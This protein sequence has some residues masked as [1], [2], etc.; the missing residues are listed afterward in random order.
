[1]K[2]QT[3]TEYLIIVAIVII[4]ALVVV[5]TL[6]GVTGL[7]NRSAD[8]AILATQPLG[9]TSFTLTSGGA[10]FILKNNVAN[11]V[12]VESITLDGQL[13]SPA[14][15]TYPIT[16]AVG[17]AQQIR[18][19]AAF[20]RGLTGRAQIGITYIDLATN[21][22]YSKNGTIS[23]TFPALY[24][25]NNIIGYWSFDQMNDT[26]ITDVMGNTT[27][28]VRNV[29]TTRGVFGSAGYFNNS[30]NAYITLGTTLGNFET[31]QDFSYSAWVY[32]ENRSQ[33]TGSAAWVFSKKTFIVINPTDAG[34]GIGC[35]SGGG[36]VN[37]MSNGSIPGTSYGG[38]INNSAWTHVVVSATRST[39]TYIMYVN[40]MQSGGTTA[41]PPGNMSNTLQLTIGGTAAGGAVP[42]NVTLD[43]VMLFNRALS[44][45]EVQEM[46]QMSQG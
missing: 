34:W 28:N 25:A 6:G 13:L 2:F 22:Q 32:Y 15:L 3:A 43:E 17:E 31:N 38:A 19:Y 45:T 18:S 42:L 8:T 26:N 33:C 14:R 7:G 20:P 9:I 12:R 46:Y 10:I 29:T 44:T 21:A 41:I 40:G 5:T 37:V 23:Y 1:M 36:L 30:K 35:Y 4:I 27:G 24:F 11:A 39:N 16:L